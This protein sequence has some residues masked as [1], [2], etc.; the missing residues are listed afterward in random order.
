MFYAQDHPGAD[1]RLKA[2]FELLF[3]LGWAPAENQPKPLRP[4][5][6]THS[7]AAALGTKENP[8]SD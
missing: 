7:L 4:G 1:G 5:S 6:A 8:L 2:T 3:L